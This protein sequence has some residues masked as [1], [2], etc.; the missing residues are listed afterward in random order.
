MNAKQARAMSLNHW[1]H[2][3][4]AKIQMAILEASQEGLHTSIFALDDLVTGADSIT[5]VIKILSVL[6]GRLKEQGYKTWVDTT[7]MYVVSWEE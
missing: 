2:V 5:S 6:D 3:A 7:G 1:I 4:D